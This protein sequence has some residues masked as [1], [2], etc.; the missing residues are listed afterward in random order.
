M[1]ET[2]LQEIL[3]CQEITFTLDTASD[4]LVYAYQP[5]A[6]ATLGV[7]TQIFDLID[8]TT[9]IHFLPMPSRCS[10]NPQELVA[11]QNLY[12]TSQ[13]AEFGYTTSTLRLCCFV[14]KIQKDINVD[15]A[16]QLFR[17]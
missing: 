8:F 17:G 16:K 9:S 13:S 3:G 10:F 2:H 15:D 1:T 7:S 5:I 4:S 11:K 6:I 14:P 12:C